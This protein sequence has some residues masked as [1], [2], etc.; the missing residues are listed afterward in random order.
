MRAV[1]LPPALS[2]VLPL[3]SRYLLE[4]LHP[5]IATPIAIKP[6]KISLTPEISP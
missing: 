2:P 5:A 3:K 6:H 1:S 4:F